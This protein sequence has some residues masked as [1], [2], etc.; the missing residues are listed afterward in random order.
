[1]QLGPHDIVRP[2]LVSWR[3]ERLP[4]PADLRPITVVPD[5]VCEVLSPSTAAHD[6]ITKRAVYARSGIRHYWIIDVDAHTL[7]AFELLDQR[8]LLAGTYG[9]DA[10]ARIA[11]F[12]QIELAVRRLFLPKAE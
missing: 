7:K 1:V 9:D 3:R 4:N 6:K 2:D 12:E 5:W 10:L 11:P 8:W